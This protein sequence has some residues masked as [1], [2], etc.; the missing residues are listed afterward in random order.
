MRS[1]VSTCP[2][3][4]ACKKCHCFSVMMLCL[5][6]SNLYLKTL[7]HKIGR[8]DNQLLLHLVQSPKAQRKQNSTR[9]L[10][11]HW[12]N[13]LIC[14]R[15]RVQRSVRL[16]HGWWAKSVNIMLRSFLHHKLLLFS[17]NNWL[18]LS[19]TFQKYPTKLAQ[20]SRNSLNHLLLM[21]ID[22]NQ[23]LWLLSLMEYA[24]F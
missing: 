21:I 19:K 14:S 2:V 15:I 11:H 8:R 22:N 3:V 12:R 1:G 5:W 10:C 16:F 4:A 13:L 23:M 20:L 6:S 17:S 24:M 9:Y 7:N 18:K